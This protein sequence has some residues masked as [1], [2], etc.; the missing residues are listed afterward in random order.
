MTSHYRVLRRVLLSLSL[1]L[2]AAVWL[3]CAEPGQAPEI[4]ASDSSAVLPAL[5]VSNPVPASAVASGLSST[6]LNNADEVA[7]ISMP[8]GALP[9]VLSVRIRNVTTIGPPTE[10]VPVI[11]GGFDPV[12]VAARAGDRLALIMSLNS[13]AATVSYFSVPVRRPPKD[14]AHGATQRANGRGT[15]RSPADR[16]Q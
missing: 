1:G 10:I 16:I 14:R 11:D 8:P 15:Q 9:G 5:I 6:S 2:A 4:T 13:G 7:Y 3:S 12:A